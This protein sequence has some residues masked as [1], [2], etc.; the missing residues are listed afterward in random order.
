MSLQFQ[1]PAEWFTCFFV[2]Y[3]V[4]GVGMAL[5]AVAQFFVERAEEQRERA[6]AEIA[7]NTKVK[8]SALGRVVVP[9]VSPATLAPSTIGA[10]RRTNPFLN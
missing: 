4:F 2:F 10:E 5:G 7:R 1:P 3:G 9:S 8:T 6:M